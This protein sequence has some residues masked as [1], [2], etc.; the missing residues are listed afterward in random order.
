MSNET[1]ATRIPVGEFLL[2]SEPSRKVAVTSDSAAEASSAAPSPWIA[3]A[4]IS[5]A[6]FCSPRV[7][8]ERPGSRMAKHALAV[9]PSLALITRSYRHTKENQHHDQRNR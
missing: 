3:R 5:H 7:P 1:R 8:P 6:W 2:R 4:A 9:S